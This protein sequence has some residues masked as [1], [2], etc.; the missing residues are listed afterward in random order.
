[1]IKRLIW[2]LAIV[3]ALVG[4]AHADETVT[5]YGKEFPVMEETVVLDD[6]AIGSHDELEAALP[7]FSNLKQVDMCRC[8]IPDEEMAALNAAHP[9]IKFVW[10]VD[11]GHWQVRTDIKHFATWSTVLDEDGFII[12]AKN[13]TK[14]NEKKLNA[15]RYCTDLVALDLGHNSIKNVEFISGLTNLE[16]LIIALNEIKDISPLENLKNLK[17]LEIFN[18]D[19]RDVSVLAKL[20]KLEYVYM[21]SIPVKDISCLYESKQLKLLFLE[22]YRFKPEARAEIA[23][24]LPGCEVLYRSMNQNGSRAWRVHPCYLEMRRALG[25]KVDGDNE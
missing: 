4:A 25:V 2:G 13:I 5:L 11:L 3:L 17:Y 8:G 16:Y 23:E 19:I 12:S 9:D 1:M 7:Q 10:E 21:C 6:I 18:N 20:P 15:L 14:Q 22:G 24:A